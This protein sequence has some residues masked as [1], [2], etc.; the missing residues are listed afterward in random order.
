MVGS[1]HPALFLQTK[2]QTKIINDAG[3]NEHVCIVNYK[4]YIYYKSLVQLGSLRILQFLLVI[5]SAWE[6]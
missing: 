2:V 4:Q 6:S 5:K 1:H 3:N